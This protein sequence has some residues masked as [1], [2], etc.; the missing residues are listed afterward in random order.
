[1]RKL[2]AQKRCCRLLCLLCALVLCLAIAGCKKDEEKKEAAAESSGTEAPLTAEKPKAPE[3][4]EEQQKS[5]ALSEPEKPATEQEQAR[6]VLVVEYA[7][8]TDKAFA[9][10]CGQEPA[11]I[12]AGVLL[13]KQEFDAFVIG[14]KQGDHCLRRQLSV[15]KDAFS[16]EETKALNASL[17]KMDEQRTAM[18]QDYDKLCAYIADPE[19]VDN[20]ARGDEL[21]KQIGGHMKSYA[22]AVVAYRDVLDK[23]SLE[24]QNILLKGHP[25]KDHVLIAMDIASLIH[26]QADAISLSEPDPDKMDAPL[27]QLEE[28]IT[29]ADRLPFPIAGTPEMYYRH[30]LKEASKMAALFRTGQKESFHKTI[31]TELNTGWEECS[32]QYNKFVDAVNGL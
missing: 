10:S 7:N 21:T 1:M 11:R 17:G 23:A 31:R 28:K 16:E 5:Y 12:M 8:K 30:F 4:P 15:P 13:Y 2:L 14:D 19:I 3:K 32:R 20:G 18:R 24:A 22:E 29:T 26:K 25:L 9:T 27:A 6:A